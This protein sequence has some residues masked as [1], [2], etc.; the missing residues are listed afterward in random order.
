M[1]KISLTIATIIIFIATILISLYLSKDF[2]YQKVIKN[3]NDFIGTFSWGETEN[4]IENM[5]YLAII[6]EDNPEDNAQF[7]AYYVSNEKVIAHGEWIFTN[8][9]YI[10]L[11]DENKN[12]FAHIVYVP[13]GY[14]L[15]NNENEAI[16]LKKISI[17]PVLPPNKDNV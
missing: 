8:N 17:A 4:N 5:V 2:F 3:K 10:T 16:K 6:K 11:L 13:D 12:T 15:F 7:I 14:L 9:N 1:K